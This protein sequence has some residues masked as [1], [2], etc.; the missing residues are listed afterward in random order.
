MGE[1]CD[2]NE[3]PLCKISE[4]WKSFVRAVYFCSAAQIEEQFLAWPACAGRLRMTTEDKIKRRKKGKEKRSAQQ[5]CGPT[6]R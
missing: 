6:K 4:K 3:K 1:P 5:C 2:V